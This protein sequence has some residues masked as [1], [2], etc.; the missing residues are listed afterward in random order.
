M[1]EITVASSLDAVTPSKIRELADY[2]FGMDDV[3]KLHFGESNMPT[4]DYIKQA[5]AHALAEGYT[6]YTENGGL[7][8]LRQRIAEK[9]AELHAV[10]VNPQTEIVITA[11]GTQAVNVAMRC[12][13]DPGSETIVLTPN[14]PNGTEVTRLYGANPHEVPLAFDGERYC[15]D[16]DALDEAVS[17][18]T[19]MLIYSSPNNPTGWVAT[20]EEQQAL[21]DFCRRHD[22]WLL[23]D[24]V[25]ERLYYDGP[26]APSIL[27]QCSRD[28][29]V[30][31]TQ[32]FSKT[33]CMTGWRLGWLTARSDLAA[34]AKQ[35]NEFIISSAPA[36]IQ[37]AGITALERGDDDVNAMVETYQEQMQFCYDALSP[38]ERVTLP[39]PSGAFYLFPSIEGVDD[40]F[41]FAVDML[42][43]TNVSVSPGSAFGAGGEGSIRICFASDMSVLE[44]AMERMVNYIEKG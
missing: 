32:S 6:Y 17:E 38:V 18:R 19:R 22:M 31:V 36:M 39:K 34:K 5:V 1:P 20:V 43:A 14:W 23:A 28:D 7:P 35:L 42:K 37:R 12:V 40:S 9:T 25:Y 4:A 26:V 41:A 10:Q 21:L 16:M 33:Y 24:E 8:E 13:I 27:Q 2:A 30:I 29:A 11:S 3:L 15:V 44:P